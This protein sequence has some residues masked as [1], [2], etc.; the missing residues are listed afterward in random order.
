MTDKDTRYRTQWAAQFYVAA[1]T[2]DESLETG[3][4]IMS[5]TVE[6]EDASTPGFEPIV[7]ILSIVIIA[8]III[9]IIMALIIKKQH[10]S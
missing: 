4:Y 5:F 6:V 3:E 8:L 7:L 9:I 10:S 1:T 2:T